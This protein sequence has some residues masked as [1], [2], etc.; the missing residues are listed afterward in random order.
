MRPITALRHDDVLELQRDA[1]N[2]AVQRLVGGPPLVRKGSAGPAVVR[3]QQALIAAGAQIKADGSFGPATHAAVV[4]FQTGASLTPDGVVGPRTWSALGG[5]G[6]GGGAGATPSG[7]VAILKSKLA[8][9]QAKIAQMG[10]KPGAAKEAT[11]TPMVEPV[12]RGGW[13]DD[14][15]EWASG[16]G[17]SVGDA[18]SAV[19]EAV[20][21]VASAVGE[22]VGGVADTVGGAIDDVTGAV[23]G[24]VGGASDWIEDKVGEA[25]QWMSD[26]AGE[27]GGFVDGVVDGLGKQLESLGEDVSGLVGPIVGPIMDGIADLAGGIGLTPGQVDDLIARVE[28]ALSQLGAV[29][30]ANDLGAE[31]GTELG[32]GTPG[33]K[34]S[35]SAPSSVAAK[36]TFSD[37]DFNTLLATLTSR[38]AAGEEIGSCLPTVTFTLNGA[39][40]GDGLPDDEKVT[41]AF[42]T[43]VDNIGL[44]DWTNA[45]NAQP[46]QQKAWQNFAGGVA[47][48]EAL[49]AADDK[50]FLG[51]LHT[52][53]LGKTVKQAV[54][55]VNKQIEASNDQSPKRDTASPPPTL[56]PAGITKVP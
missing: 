54:D 17:E 43:V 48:H 29:A 15:E 41:S 22:A 45:S 39:S 47:S 24:A 50:G 55:F 18:A 7:K 56:R 19:G 42:F 5:G 16:V 20:G 14:A 26:A 3:L 4:A 1:G 10:G 13:L 25:G 2:H 44:P 9:L 51:S 28:R 37:A 6:G 53:C 46:D 52:G 31:A 36:Y 30:V 27:V 35:Y 34:T 23:G 32:G 21:D 11:S 40:G 12:M 38:Q 8:M 49:H 33:G